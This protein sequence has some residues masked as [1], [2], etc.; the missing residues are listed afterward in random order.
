MVIM[1][2]NMENNNSLKMERKP[3]MWSNDD[4]TVWYIS[5]MVDFHRLAGK[6]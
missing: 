4:P 3:T 6:I 2:H 1:K 5:V